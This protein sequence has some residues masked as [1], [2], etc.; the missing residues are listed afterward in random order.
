MDRHGNNFETRSKGFTNIFVQ[1]G[2]WFAN[3]IESFVIVG[4]K[5]DQ[6]IELNRIEIENKNAYD[7]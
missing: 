3:E 6:T 7:E 5:R 1:C 2:E 4:G